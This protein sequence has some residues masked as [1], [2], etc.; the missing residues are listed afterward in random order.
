MAVSTR[1]GADPLIGVNGG[2]QLQ[3][4]GKKVSHAAVCHAGVDWRRSD[5][6]ARAGSRDRSRQR[7]TGLLLAWDRGGRSAL[8]DLMPLVPEEL[9][10]LAR[11]WLLR[12]ISRRD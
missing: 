10:R 12:E 3:H 4:E 9:R 8:D 7:V 5:M 6:Q 1:F 11:V 2:R